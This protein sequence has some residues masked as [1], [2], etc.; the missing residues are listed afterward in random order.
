MN[1]IGSKYTLRLFLEGVFREVSDGSERVL[2]DIF[3]GTG[4]V[5]RHFKYLGFQIIAN[6]IQYYSYALNKAY[7]EINE[8]PPFSGLRAR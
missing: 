5:G 4:A 1:Y 6:D 7:I 2:C 3:A 8:A